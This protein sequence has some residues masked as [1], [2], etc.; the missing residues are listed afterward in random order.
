VFIG[1]TSLEANIFIFFNKIFNKKNTILLFFVNLI[2]CM[3]FL[4]TSISRSDQIIINQDQYLIITSL[5]V[6]GFYLI[7]KDKRAEFFPLLLF[8]LVENI[9]IQ[10]MLNILMKSN[11]FLGI[12]PYESLLNFALQIFISYILKTHFEHTIAMLFNKKR[13]AIIAMSG[14]LLFLTF[15]MVVSNGQLMGNHLYIKSDGITSNENVQIQGSK[16]LL[17]KIRR[18]ESKKIYQKFLTFVFFIL[19]VACYISFEVRNNRR[20]KHLESEKIMMENYI[21]TLER[22]ELDIQKVQHDYRNMIIGISGFFDEDEVDISGL[23]KF[24]EKNKII[25]N[26]LRLKIGTINKL[27]MINLPAVKGMV[28]SKMITSVQQGIDVFVECSEKVNIR[29]VDQFDLS[30]ALGIILDNSIEECEKQKNGTIKI[31]FINVSPETVIIVTNTCTKK[32]LNI[33]PGETSKGEHHGMG[34][35]NLNEIIDR[36]SH[37]SLETTC[38]NYIFTQKILIH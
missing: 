26:S 21:D 36:S 24:L 28:L 6:G 17:Y 14:L 3:A 32:T 34:L 7:L 19:F 33:V 16:E 37:L 30:R 12:I 20:N 31:V 25:Q 23:R 27:K 18:K 10:Q 9:F 22:M 13:K 4:F 29:N 38:D 8:F 5:V 15:Q 11:L 2:V 35:Q 1:I